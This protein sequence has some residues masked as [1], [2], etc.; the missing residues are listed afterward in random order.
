MAKRTDFSRVKKKTDSKS[1][2]FNAFLF[3][4]VK[5]KYGVKTGQQVLDL[6]EKSFEQLF[7]PFPGNPAIE[8]NQPDNMPS[9]SLPAEYKTNFKVGIVKKEPARKPIEDPT[10]EGLDMAKGWVD[11]EKRIAQ[12]EDEIKKGPPNDFSAL[13]KKNYLFDRNKELNQ[14]KNEKA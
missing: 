5:N 2:R 8:R 4:K 9:I 11:R 14:L 13:A 7:F 3:E 10:K 6:Y 1:V 12:L